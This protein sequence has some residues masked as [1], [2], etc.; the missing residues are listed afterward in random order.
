M[1]A[2]ACAEEGQWPPWGALVGASAAAAASAAHDGDGA[3]LPGLTTVQ[4]AQHAAAQAADLGGSISDTG[5]AAMG[6]AGA[7]TAAA[8]GVKGGQPAQLTTSGG[9]DLTCPGAAG[10]PAQDY[11]AGYSPHR[12][13]AAERRTQQ[14]EL[15][16]LSQWELG[17][18]RQPGHQ[19]SVPGFQASTLRCMLGVAAQLGDRVQLLAHLPRDLDW[20]G[21]VR[22]TM[23]QEGYRQ[24]SR[25]AALFLLKQGI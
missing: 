21:R 6:T 16:R 19:Q 2:A 14:Q 10:L 3:A 1:V 11:R 20:W 7:S 24:C 12:N 13:T 5:W 4:K 23:Q 22:R 18:A 8:G 9:S 17:P 25:D 15:R